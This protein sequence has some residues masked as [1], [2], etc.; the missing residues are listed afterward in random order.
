MMLEPPF[1]IHKNRCFFVTML[2]FT[3]LA[4]S[5]FGQEKEDDKKPFLFDEFSISVNRNNMPH[6]RFEN[7]FGGGAGMYQSSA[8][9]KQWH[10]MYG[11]EYNYTFLFVDSMYDYQGI[12]GESKNVTFHVHTVFVM[13]LAFRFSIGNNIKYFLESG[14]FLGLSI[15]EIKGDTYTLTQPTPSNPSGITKEKLNDNMAWLSG[16]TSF[17]IGM[18]IPMK[19]IEWIV[20]ADYRVGLERIDG[21]V[22]YQYYR[23]GVGIRK[24]T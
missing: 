2:F 17:G 15:A 7:G 24:R 12:Y 22:L 19:G 16:G 10:R 6:P 1:F 21:Y 20:K 8:L 14:L 5:I 23:L 18:R 11:W 9:S 13:P 4:G 3:L